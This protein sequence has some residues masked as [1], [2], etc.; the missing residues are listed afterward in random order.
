MIELNEDILSSFLKRINYDFPIPLDKKVNIDEYVK[1]ILKGTIKVYKC[2]NKILGLVAGYTENIINNS[3]YISIVAVDKE[4]RGQGI[5]NLLI[6]EFINDCIMKNIESINLYTH[7]TNINAIK[8]YKRLG[9]E[10]NKVQNKD[11]RDDIH[12]VYRIV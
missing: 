4:F 6:K 2:N 3:A 12:L 9:F 10:E 11:R 8:M 1:K 5:A 7:S